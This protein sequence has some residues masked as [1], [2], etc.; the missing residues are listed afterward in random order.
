MIKNSISFSSGGIERD[1][2]G[3]PRML[4]ESPNSKEYRCACVKLN[5]KECEEIKGMIREFPQCPKTSTKCAV[6]TEN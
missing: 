6:K 3:V 1:W 4:F 2:V 5:S